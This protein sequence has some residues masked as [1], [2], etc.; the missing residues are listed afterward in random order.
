MESSNVQTNYKLVRVG[1]FEFTGTVLGKGNYSAVR[2]AINT[3]KNLRVALKIISL[4]NARDNYV[5]LNYKREAEILAKLKHK[6][7]IHLFEVIETT[8][9]YIMVLELVPNNLCDF[10]RTCNRGRLDEGTTRV[11]FRQMVS[12]LIY[13]HNM[14][15]IH[16]DIKLENILIDKTIQQI[17]IT[18]KIKI[19]IKSFT[20]T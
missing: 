2:E 10:I 13:I 11:Y 14:G 9:H 5:R 18:G 4:Q 16:R 15:I 8:K 20:F 17:K 7:V 3:H 6:N 19:L 1:K 12:A